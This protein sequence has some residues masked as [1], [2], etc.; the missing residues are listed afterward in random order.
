MYKN[1]EGVPQDLVLA[2]AWLSL[3]AIDGMDISLTSRDILKPL[4]SEVELAE[5]CLLYTSRCV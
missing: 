2:Y 4:L 3:S 1:G 5:A